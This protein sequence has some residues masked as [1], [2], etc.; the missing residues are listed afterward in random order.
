MERGAGILKKKVDLIPEVAAK[1]ALLPI[2]KE[3]VDLLPV[4]VEKIELLPIVKETVDLLPPIVEKVDLL[5][6]I[7]TETDKI[8]DIKVSAD[9]IEDIKTSTDL[10]ASIETETDKIADVKT[11]T[12]LVPDIK[13]ST[14]FIPDIKLETDKIESVYQ[15][16]E[17]IEHHFHNYRTILGKAAVPDGEI[18]VADHMGDNNGSFQIDAGN[19]TWGAWVLIVGSGDTP[20]RPGSTKYDF[21]NIF[22]TAAERTATYYIQ[23]G[24]GE[25]GAAALAAGT[26]T[27]ELFQPQSVQGKPGTQLIYSPRINV[28]TKVWVRC[29]CPGQNTATI[30]FMIGLHCYLE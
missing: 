4:V 20:L 18:H 9:L 15:E 12:D 24:F 7:K 8:A 3:T 26:Y 17:K 16:I 13:T 11:S 21:Y 27:D 25:S 19:N 28:G 29:F 2:V 6:A 23:I 1:I 10:I 14:D 5:P 30:D 22:Y